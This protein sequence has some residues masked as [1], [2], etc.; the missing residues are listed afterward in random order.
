MKRVYADAN[1]TYGILPEVR[2]ILRD[3]ESSW[4]T[5]DG[6]TRRSVSPYLNGSAIHTE[7][8]RARAVID[9]ARSFVFSATGLTAHRH[10]VVFTSGATEGNN[11]AVLAP[12]LREDR[13]DFSGRVISSTV[14]HPSVLDPLHR[15]E[16]YGV[17]VV[18]LAPEPDGTLS[19]ERVLA[20][21][22]PHTKLLSLVW[23][24]NETGVIFPIPEIFSAVREQFPQCLLHVDAVQSFSKLRSDLSTFPFDILTLSPHKFGALP[25]V[26]VSILSQHLPHSPLLLGGGQELRWRPGTENL[27][28][29]ASVAAALSALPE[30]WERYAERV[31]KLRDRLEAELLARFPGCSVIGRGVPRLPNTSLLWIQGVR[32]DDLVVALDLEGVSCSRGA[33]CSSGKQLGSHVLGGMGLP[34]EAGQEVLR[35]SFRADFEDEELTLLRDRLFLCLERLGLATPR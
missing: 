4:Q 2:E 32:T 14:E 33:A 12:F 7:G 27:I 25:G 1:A 11:S 18:R 31:S 16:R 6:G 21:L 5:S 20:E 8:Q 17:E 13:A 28:G 3:Y 26:G 24:N 29:I 35:L 22:S 19:T 34:P 9:S 30:R 23:A 10:H 15:L